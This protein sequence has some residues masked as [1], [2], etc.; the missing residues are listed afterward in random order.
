MEVSRHSS[1]RKPHVHTRVVCLSERSEQTGSGRGADHPSVLLFPEVWP[2]GMRALV[3]SKDVDPVDQIPVCLLHVLEADIAQDTRIV[4]EDVNATECVDSS[5]DDGLSV[6]DRIVVG[7]R[8]SAS[9]ADGVNDL[10]C[11]L[12]GE[13]AMKEDLLLG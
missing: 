1:L 3:C 4:D 13:L 10:V 7:D 11:G 8:L 12:S 5:L 6:L 2:R 9:G